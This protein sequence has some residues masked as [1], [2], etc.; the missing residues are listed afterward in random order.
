MECR[1]ISVRVG[2]FALRDISFSIPLGSHAALT[3]P[4]ASG[5]TTLL[6]VIA[7]ALAPDSGE[8]TVHGRVVTRKPPEERSV[9]F[10]PQ[11]GF[12]FPHLDVR[13]NIQYGLRSGSDA[14]DI[15][16]RF[17]VAHLLH[18]SVASLSGGERQL[19]AVCRALA[20]AAPLLLLD[21]PFSALDGTRRAAALSAL[22]V[23]QAERGFTVLHVTHQESDDSFA[24]HTLRMA[25][26]TLTVERGVA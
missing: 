8:V 23:L 1:N 18:R 5:K 14:S 7:G 10:V 11:H 15:I 2:S 3:G 24:T 17:A 12:L 19:V 25:D 21:E 20:P 9:G 6:E 16:A 26:G 13:D 4:T 22:A